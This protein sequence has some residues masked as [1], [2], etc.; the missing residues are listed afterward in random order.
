ML[1][2]YH[3]FPHSLLDSWMQMVFHSYVNTLFQRGWSLTF[4]IFWCKNLRLSKYTLYSMYKENCT[5]KLKWARRTFFQCHCHGGKKLNSTQLK[6]DEAENELM[7]QVPKEVIG[8]L[9]QCDK[10]IR[11]SQLAPVELMLFPSHRDWEIGARAFFLVYIS[12]G[13][14]SGLR[15]GHSCTGR[16]FTFQRQRKNLQVLQSQ[17]SKKK[18][19]GDLKARSSLFKCSQAKKES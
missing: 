18:E 9:G 15:E 7:H 2:S 17:C 16:V 10:T 14:L 3:L 19:V 12:E 4:C 1:A 6:Q 5:T 11:V 8:Q 13:W